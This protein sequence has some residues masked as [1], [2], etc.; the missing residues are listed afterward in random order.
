VSAD[1]RAVLEGRIVKRALEDAA[2]R[3]RLVERPREAVA[4]ELGVDLPDGLEV[5]VVEERPDRIAIVLPFDL[6]GL[7]PDAVW[8]MTGRRPS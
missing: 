2:F 6:S 8:A 5:V 4:E 3:A 1:E 7:G